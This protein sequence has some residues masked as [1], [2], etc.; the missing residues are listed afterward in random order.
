VATEPAIAEKIDYQSVVDA[1]IVNSFDLKLTKIDVRLG[2]N[3]VLRGYSAFLPT[4]QAQA[5]IEYLK[6]MTNGQTPV[7]V[8]GTTVIP[9]STRF[10]NALYVG[11]NYTMFDFG[12]RNRLLA[13]AKKH[14]DSVRSSLAQYRRNLILDVIDQY[15]DALSTYLALRGKLRIVDI[16]RELFQMKKRLFIAGRINKVE[17]SEAAVELARAFAEVHDLK[18][19]LANGLRALSVHTHKDY[20]VEQIE[21]SSFSDNDLIAL[22]KP[23]LLVENSPE[24]KMYKQSIESKRQELSALKRQRLPQFGAYSNFYMYGFNQNV[25]YKSFQ[26]FRGRT[27]SFGISASMPIFDGFKNRLD[28]RQKQLEITR[29][30]I[31][32]DK[33]LWELQQQHSQLRTAVGVYE[34]VLDSKHGLVSQGA[35]KVVMAK[36]LGDNDLIEKTDYLQHQSKLIEDEL[37][38]QRT[39]VQQTASQKKLKV[40]SEG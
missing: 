27:L 3:E 8:V 13:A 4:M 15:A 26:D 30:E 11:A 37:D 2:D 38:L 24:Y 31:E 10:Q 1:A 21:V 17:V 20:D 28:C 22:E 5:N 34:K 39:K 16:D 12:A 23:I 33:K 29:L 35:E 25:W 6:D 36:R 7:A 9:N 40:L 14:R 32:R 18:Q 19:R